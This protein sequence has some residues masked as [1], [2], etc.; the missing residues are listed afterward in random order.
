MSIK[1]A[2]KSGAGKECCRTPSTETDDES[3]LNIKLYEC[4][5]APEHT[6]PKSESSFPPGK[7]LE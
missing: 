6:C 5:P 3:A 2:V 1:R 7:E 4:Q